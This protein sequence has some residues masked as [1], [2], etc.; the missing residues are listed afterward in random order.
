MCA[1]SFFGTGNTKAGTATVT[2]GANMLAGSSVTS[3]ASSNLVAVGVQTIEAGTKMRLGVYADNAGK[4]GTLLAQTAELTT[5]ANAA[6]EGAL[7]STAITAGTRY[8]IMVLTNNTI[9][10]AAE[11]ATVTW[12]FTSSTTYGPLPSTATTTSAT[13]NLGDLYIVTAP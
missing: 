3:G 2:I 5:V 12:Y 7:P 6:T 4:P 8:W 1:A 9:D 13:L 11:T 10:L